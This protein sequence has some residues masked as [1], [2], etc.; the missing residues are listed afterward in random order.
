VLVL[1]QVWAGLA[2]ETVFVRG[3]CCGHVTSNQAQ[4]SFQMGTEAHEVVVAEAANA[5]PQL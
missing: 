4:E 2:G 3:T 1:E 5:V